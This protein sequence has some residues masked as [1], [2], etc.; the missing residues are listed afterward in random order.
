MPKREPSLVED[1]CDKWRTHILE[2]KHGVATT[3]YAFPKCTDEVVEFSRKALF[4]V[5]LTA[6]DGTNPSFRPEQIIA[7]AK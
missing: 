1:L 5:I 7:F 6:K 2:E 4:P 3:N